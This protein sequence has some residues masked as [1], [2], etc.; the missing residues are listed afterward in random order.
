MSKNAKRNAA[1]VSPKATKAT[2]ATDGLGRPGTAARFFRET[3]LARP[4]LSNAEIVALAT[5]KFPKV[6][7]APHWAS[8]YRAEIVRNSER[9]GFG[10]EAAAER[11]AYGKGGR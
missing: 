7:I 9:R 2:K 5:K 6:A 10:S 8:W 11:A 3:I 1:K 4:N